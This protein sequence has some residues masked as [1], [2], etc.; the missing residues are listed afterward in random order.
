MEGGGEGCVFC[1][2]PEMGWGW[3]G[4]QKPE[5]GWRGKGMCSQKSKWG[6]CVQSK[7]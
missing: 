1:Q 6:V 7:T 3:M 4:G 2:K 5:I